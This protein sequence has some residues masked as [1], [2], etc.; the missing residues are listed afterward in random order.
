M[1]TTERLRRD[2]R[3]QFDCTTQERRQIYDAAAA[4]G[5]DV[6]PWCRFIL[7]AAARNANA[8]SRQ[9]PAE[10]P[11]VQHPPRALPP[12]DT[13]RS[14]AQAMHMPADTKPIPPT[15]DTKPSQ[16][17]RKQLPWEPYGEPQDPEDSDGL[18]SPEAIVVPGLGSARFK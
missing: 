10:Y 11:V 2:H 15:A 16:P 14:P 1:R 5:L 13:K 17:K 4:S 9:H 6:A 18:D 3:L 12:D 7:L 8:D